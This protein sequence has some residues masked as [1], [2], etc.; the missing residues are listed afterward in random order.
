MKAVLLLCALA[1]TALAAETPWSRSTM[2]MH[3]GI[4]VLSALTNGTTIL[5]LWV[6]CNYFDRACLAAPPVDQV[7]E[8]FTLV[9]RH[10]ITNGQREHYRLQVEGRPIETVQAPTEEIGYRT[11][12]SML[13]DSHPRP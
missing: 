13:L 5:D 3:G 12:Y 7:G 9:S 8:R 6:D 1:G 2:Q 4:A 11:S 10:R